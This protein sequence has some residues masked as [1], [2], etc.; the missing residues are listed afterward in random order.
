VQAAN[1]AFYGGLHQMARVKSA[2][3]KEAKRAIANARQARKDVEYQKRL[4]KAIW[5]DK[6]KEMRPYLKKLRKIDL[7][8]NLSTGQKSFVSKA[9]ADYQALTIRPTKVYRTKNKA[10]IKIAS[11]LYHGNRKVHFDVAF[12]PTADTKAKIKFNKKGDMILSSK[13]VDEVSIKFN[14]FNMA[15]DPE[16]EIARVLVAN[17]EYSDFIIMAD[18]YLYNGAISRSLIDKELL[19][20]MSRYQPGGSVYDNPRAKNSGPNHHWKN[21]LLGIK[22]FKAKNQQAIADYRKAYNQAVGA[23]K[24]KRN[25]A[26]RARKAKAK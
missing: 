3:S 7:R 8:H 20:L 26:N 10:H 23:N 1:G 24:K 14:M 11:E 2:L 19:K 4:A 12:I 13:Y 5:R 22:G 18:E 15:V 21:W 25:K 17:P 9:W 6:I 16:K